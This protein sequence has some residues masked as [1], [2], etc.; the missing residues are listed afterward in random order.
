M[1]EHARAHTRTHNMYVCLYGMHV[2]ASGT[3]LLWLQFELLGQIFS[4][5]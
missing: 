4:L 1:Y 3:L 5:S 2:Q